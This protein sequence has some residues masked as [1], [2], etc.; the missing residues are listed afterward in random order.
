MHTNEKSGH[1]LRLALAADALANGV[2]GPLLLVTAKSL[3]PL[4]GLAPGLLKSAGAIML[5]AGAV[6]AWLASQDRPP[7]LLVWLFVGGNAGWALLSLSLLARDTLTTIGAAAVIAQA[8]VVLTFAALQFIG[9][10]RMPPR[11]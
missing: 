4:L 5:P 10:R 1:L 2:A 9:L 11:R 3:A 8:L 7:R 6:L